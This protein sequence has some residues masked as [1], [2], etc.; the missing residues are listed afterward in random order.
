[1][2]ITKVFPADLI[3]ISGKCMSLVMLFV[4]DLLEQFSSDFHCSAI[5]KSLS[6]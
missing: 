3:C 1:M 5:Q 2:C 6:E 4:F